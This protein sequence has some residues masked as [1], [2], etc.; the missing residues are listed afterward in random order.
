MLD[1][2]IVA[3]EPPM[4]NNNNNNRASEKKKEINPFDGSE[5]QKKHSMYV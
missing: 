2:R 5:T 3:T 4:R 1:G